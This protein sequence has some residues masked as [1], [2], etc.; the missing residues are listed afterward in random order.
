M[1]MT[2]AL[3]FHRLPQLGVD[4]DVVLEPDV[5]E[6]VV[7]PHDLGAEIG[8]RPDQAIRDLR[9]MLSYDLSRGEGVEDMVRKLDDAA[10]LLPDAWWRKPKP[11]GQDNKAAL[12]LKWVRDLADTEMV[13]ERREGIVRSIRRHIVDRQH[14]YCAAYVVC[15]GLTIVK[16]GSEGSASLDLTSM[17]RNLEC[18]RIHVPDVS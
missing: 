9:D 3:L 8:T 18:R 6:S 17:P 12:F 11:A 1:G 5:I 2:A 4:I 13:N 10:K 16:L 14:D 15:H 7:F